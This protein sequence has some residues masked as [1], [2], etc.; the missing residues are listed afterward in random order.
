MENIV[1]N[2]FYK[3]FSVP[4]QKPVNARIVPDYYQIIHSPIDLTTIGKQVAKQ[5][6]KTAQH[7]LEDFKLILS[8]ATL[9]NGEDNYFTKCAQLVYE[10]VES[11]LE[12]KAIELA[13][14]EAAIK[15]SLEDANSD[16]EN[17][18]PENTMI[19]IEK[20]RN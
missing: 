15:A 16:S 4:F 14:Y 1:G 12:E 5:H 6:Y 17:R 18:D 3:P 10:F 7:F 11:S 9:Y 8:N 20:S 13:E 2:L 19:V